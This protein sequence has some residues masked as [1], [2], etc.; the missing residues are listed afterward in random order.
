MNS[1]A[2]RA[3]LLQLATTWVE[4]AQAC[5]G[6]RWTSAGYPEA[7]PEPASPE[8][9]ASYIR[10]CE[11]LLRFATEVDRRGLKVIVGVNVSPAH[12]SSAGIALSVTM[13]MCS[14]RL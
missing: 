7:S 14:L 4:D 1:P 10:H 3:Q 13:R 11:A 12:P 9:T 5:S 2:W 6:P 8:Q